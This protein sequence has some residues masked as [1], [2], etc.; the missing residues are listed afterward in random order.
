MS[1]LGVGCVTCHVTEAGVVLAP[2][3]PEGEPAARAPHPVR[4]S[5]AFA[6]AGA[7]EGCHEFRFPRPGDPAD[8]EL[9]MQTTAREHR[10]S[11]SAST[12]CAECHM[13]LRDGRRSH[14]FAE[15]R[16]PAWLRANL[17]ARAEPTQDGDLRITL[18]Q[19]NPGHDFPTGDL[20]RRLEVGVVVEGAAG[21]VLRREVR[22]LA[23]DFEIVPGRPGRSLVRDDRVASEPTVVEL[24]VTP[25]SGAPPAVRLSWWVTYQRVATVGTGSN[26]AD[27]I[28]ESRVELHSG[29][30]LPNEDRS[31]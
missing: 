24:P 18:T 12:P 16:D 27:A 4:R 25:P 9:F 13:P 26:P 20:F 22:Y 6:G 3:R 19:P 15:V 29:S 8:D 10:R 28:V 21:D 11:V 5:V 17:E 1:A 31:P 14:A 23:R 7:C 30:L 2:A